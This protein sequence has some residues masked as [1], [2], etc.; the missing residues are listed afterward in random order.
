M[1][2][3]EII[4]A[5]KECT[6]KLGRVPRQDEFRVTM[7]VRRHL[8]R[9]YFS[10]YTQLLSVCG[11][12]RHGSGVPLTMEAMFQDWASVVRST[13]KIPSVTEYDLHGTYSYRPFMSRFKSWKGVPG[14][15][16]AYAVAKGLG[17]EWEDVVK[18][19]A[20]HL[21]LP[22]EEAARY[23]LPFASTLRRSMV[24]GQP[25]YG[26]PLL[27][28]PL[29][30]APTNEAGVLAAFACMAREL[31][32]VIQRIQAEF[33]DCEAMREVDKNR[34]QR[35]RIEFEYESYNFV[36]HR[37]PPS[38][39]DLIVCWFDNWPGCP[40]EVLEL[41]KALEGLSKSSK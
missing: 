41:S 40:L 21:K 22:P 20:E 39:C 27:P 4:A 9:K 17:G 26:Q 13:G 32:F 8:I 30:F 24:E 12:E 36:E 16:L 2:R 3:D 15:M 7:S 37:H 19:V 1:T 11:L 5:A 29:T 25:V 34:W 14:E 31:G 28:G 18:V 6:A 35:V 38:G 23:K 10:T 33:P